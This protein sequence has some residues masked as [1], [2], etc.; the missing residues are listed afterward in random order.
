MQ[1][2][3]TRLWWQTRAFVI[4]MAIL[5]TVPLMWPDIPPLVDLPGHMGRFRVQLSSDQYPWLR[6]WYDFRWSLIGNLGIDL[7]IIPLTPVFGLELAVKLVVMAIPAL[8]VGGLLWIAREVHGRIPPHALFAL[9][10]SYSFPFQ[11]GFV[12]FAL[13][14]GLALCLFAL[15]LRM[16]RLAAV[17]LRAAVFVPLS[18]L[19]WLCHTFGWGVLGVLAFSAEMI[20]QHD[21]R[22][23]RQSGHWVESWLRAGLGCVPLALPM[24]LMVAWRSGDHVTGETADWFNWHAKMQWVTMVF[25]DRW[26]GWDMASGAVLLLVLIKAL[27]DPNVQYSRNLG[28][29]AVFLVAVFLLLPR[30][31]FGSAYADMRLAPFML[32]IAVLAIRPKPAMTARHATIMA[33]LGLAFFLARTAGTTASYVMFDR[34]YDRELAALDKLPVGARLVS[35]VGMRCNNPWVMS[36]LEHMPALALV[37]RAAFSNDQW[38][39]AGAQLL[40]TR[41]RAAKGFAHDPSEIVTPFQCSREWWRPVNRA[42]LQFPRDAF[43]YV[44]MIEPPSHDPRMLRDLKEVWRDGS[45]VLYR[46]DRSVPPPEFDPATMDKRWW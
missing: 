41:Y 9:P 26:L 2:G 33:V 38:S 28:L 27:R 8:T 19:L 46:V 21:L 30:I 36:R 5:A 6:D 34:V 11:F 23:N 20:R 24:V 40:T 7:A 31:V 35:F 16:A 4:A 13:S 25:R 15:W 18:C 14:M 32:A 3:E 17:R 1:G 29:S 45:S 12:N 22:K 43:D 37:R 39:M 42:L 10:L 44:W